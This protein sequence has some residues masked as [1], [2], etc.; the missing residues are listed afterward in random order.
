[1]PAMFI[2]GIKN[3]TYIIFKSYRKSG[4]NKQFKGSLKIPNTLVIKT[5]MFINEFKSLQ[6][7][8]KLD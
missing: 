5:K 2:N 4:K 7:D 1:M 8:N 6:P 3:K